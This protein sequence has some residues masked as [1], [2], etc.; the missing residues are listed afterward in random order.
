MSLPSVIRGCLFMTM[1][2][3][4]DTPTYPSNG[5]GGKTATAA[6]S[7]LHNAPADSVVL[8]GFWITGF[9]AAA[10]TVKIF[11]ADGTTQIGMDITIP[12][13]AATL[14]PTFVPAGPQGV[15]LRI[16][17]QSNNCNFAITVVGTSDIKGVMCFRR[18]RKKS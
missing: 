9:P 4:A 3:T 16:P 1:D 8:D 7:T 2:V 6:S 12:I 10:R 13:A 18:L 15:G 11:G 17:A 14:L 5:E